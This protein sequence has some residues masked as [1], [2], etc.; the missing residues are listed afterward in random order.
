MCKSDQT[1]EYPKEGEGGMQGRGECKV[2]VSPNDTN[3]TNDDV[4]TK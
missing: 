2:F 1:E 4:P 3:Y